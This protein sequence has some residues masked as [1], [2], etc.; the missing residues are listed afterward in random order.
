MNWL[1]LP[2]EY[3]KAKAK[4]FKLLG[5]AEIKPKKREKTS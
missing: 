5:Y 2:S 3:Y 1:I 4:N